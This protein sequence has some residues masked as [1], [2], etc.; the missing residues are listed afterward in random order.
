MDCNIG[1]LYFKVEYDLPIHKFSRTVRCS[2]WSCSTQYFQPSSP[3][4]VQWDP[5]LD[6]VLSISQCCSILAVAIKRTVSPR[7]LPFLSS[8]G[9]IVKKVNESR[10]SQIDLMCWGAWYPLFQLDSWCNPVM[11]RVT[12]TALL[13]IGTWAFVHTHMSWLLG[14]SNV[15]FVIH[16][17]NFVATEARKSLCGSQNL[18]AFFYSQFL[19]ASL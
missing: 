17:L 1:N 10:D 15:F 12:Y 8:S 16:P 13:S 18:T 19:G 9:E 7:R 3:F 14:E 5:R 6:F 11:S 4:L 2:S